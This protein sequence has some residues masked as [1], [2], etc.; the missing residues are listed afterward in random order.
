MNQYIPLKKRSKK[1]QKAFYSLSRRDWHGVNPVT[2]VFT[3]R[4]K[5]DRKKV[6]AEERLTL[7]ENLSELFICV[8]GLTL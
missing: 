1:E 3:D 8:L 7:K 6:K 4:K 2:R 5:F